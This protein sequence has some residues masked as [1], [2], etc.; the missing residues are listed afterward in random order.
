MVK[1][2]PYRFV[3]E[4]DGVLQGETTIRYPSDDAAEERCWELTKFLWE[5][6]SHAKAGSVNCYD[7]A[8]NFVQR[9]TIEEVLK[10]V[11]HAASMDGLPRLPVVQDLFLAL[12]PEGETR[13]ESVETTVLV[14]YKVE[15]QSSGAIVVKLGA[16]TATGQD[17]LSVQDLVYGLRIYEGE[18]ERILKALQEITEEGL[19]KKKIS[20]SRVVTDS[21]RV[22]KRLGI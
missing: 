5:N 12:A 16:K 19:S 1:M 3:F 20:P 9:Y 8:G 4:L 14:A 17:A 21:S 18:A 10:S 7:E 13:P 11:K 2:K 6:N 22:H 15:A